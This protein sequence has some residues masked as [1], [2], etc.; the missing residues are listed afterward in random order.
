MEA[1]K[2]NEL[3]GMAL[4]SP[5][6]RRTAPNGHLGSSGRSSP[7]QFV[8]DSRRSSA[9]V[10]SAPFG[11][12]EVSHL[13][14]PLPEDVHAPAEA[15]AGTC[16]SFNGV[17]SPNM[18]ANVLKLFNDDSC[19]HCCPETPPTSPTAESFQY[20]S[21]GLLHPK[22]GEWRNGEMFVASETLGP[23][24]IQAQW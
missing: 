13:S 7:A 20:T 5:V 6:P 8:V 4:F 23:M 10:T 16:A 17:Y 1:N 18:Q 21:N 11:A 12:N 19:G 3:P 24:Q 2:T 22:G 9:T 15:A 14:A